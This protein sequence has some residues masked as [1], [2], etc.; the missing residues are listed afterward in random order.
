[1]HKDIPYSVDQWTCSVR[2]VDEAQLPFT[3]YQKANR[4]AVRFA[5][6]MQLFT[7]SGPGNCFCRRNLSSR[8]YSTKSR[9]VLIA[10]EIPREKRIATRGTKLRSMGN[11]KRNVIVVNE[12]SQEKDRS[13]SLMS[14]DSTGIFAS[15]QISAL[16]WKPQDVRNFFAFIDDLRNQR[17]VVRKGG[18]MFLTSCGF[19]RGVKKSAEIY[20]DREIL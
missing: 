8:K 19:R 12:G 17:Q 6:F 13:M 16:Q 5:Y 7:R 20:Q 1:M 9:I 4:V 14:G 18:E 15:L 11:D 3:R 2:S 10:V